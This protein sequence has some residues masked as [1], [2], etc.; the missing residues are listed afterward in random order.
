MEQAF[1]SGMVPARA[2]PSVQNYVLT[3]GRHLA[4]LDFLLSS[5]LLRGEIRTLPATVR[6]G[7]RLGAAE[8]LFCDTPVYVSV[9]SWVE[10]IKLLTGRKF[11]GVANAVLRKVAGVELAAKIIK[12][13]GAV[14]QLPE[15]PALVACARGLVGGEGDWL[16]ALGGASEAHLATASSHP[17]WLIAD[18]RNRF[19][20]HAIEMLAAAQRPHRQ[21]LRWDW[22]MMKRKLTPAEAELALELEKLAQGVEFEEETYALAPTGGAGLVKSTFDAGLVSLQGVASQAVMRR[23]P[24]PATGLILDACAGVGVKSTLIA[25]LAGGAE[26]LVVADVSVDKLNELAANFE[27]IG[28]PAPRCFACDMTDREVVSNLRDAFPEG[29]AR[30]YLDAPC[31]GSGT[32]GRL[33]FKRY[34]LREKTAGEMAVKQQALISACRTL[35]AEDGDIV[36]ITCSLQQEENEEVVAAAEK[37]VLRAEKPF[38][39]VLPTEDYL[40][41]MFAARL[42]RD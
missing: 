42:S 11:A 36:Y 28:L 9:S 20:E 18:W 31:S 1:A 30:I 38:W 41:G 2:R 29:F 39:T 27:R 10:E 19:G 16:F 3:T 5:F 26:R 25:L 4:L 13:A 7:L 37:A 32:L 6:S 17:E 23:F 12:P 34:G 14:R 15:A 24:P 22:R 33:P 21:A 40:E 8:T 35:L